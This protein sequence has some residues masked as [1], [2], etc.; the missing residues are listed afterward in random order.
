MNAKSILLVDDSPV[1]LQ[2]L[3]AQLAGQGY[4]VLPAR[5]ARCADA[6]PSTESTPQ[7]GHSAVWLASIHALI[8]T[9]GNVRKQKKQPQRVLA[10]SSARCRDACF[11]ASA[12]WGSTCLVVIVVIVTTDS[13]DPDAH[14]TTRSSTQVTTADESQ[15]HAR[16][17][18]VPRAVGPQACY[19]GRHIQEGAAS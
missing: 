5:D 4:R 1:V 15:V 11:C 16:V 19:D 13:D 18:R 12:S 7:P 10:S 8:D 3:G 6:F 2:S 14:G 9:G 17:P